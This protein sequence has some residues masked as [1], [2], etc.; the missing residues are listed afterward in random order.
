MHRIHPRA[1]HT[2]PQPP[3][4]TTLH[5]CTLLTACVRVCVV[6]VGTRLGFYFE[7]LATLVMPIFVVVSA[8]TMVI[9]MRWSAGYLRLGLPE[10]VR[11]SVHFLRWAAARLWQ[12]MQTR[13]HVTHP[14]GTVSGGSGVSP[15]SVPQ[16]PAEEEAEAVEYND[17]FD[18]DEE[19][20]MYIPVKRDADGN[21]ILPGGD[22]G[23]AHGDSGASSTEALSSPS[24]P[25]SP[26]PLSSAPPVSAASREPSRPLQPSASMVGTWKE[27]RRLWD[28]REIQRKGA[29]RA[30]GLVWIRVGDESSLPPECTEA[31]S[32]PKLE[33]SL[34]GR[35]QV[36]FTA[37]QWASFAVGASLRMRHYVAV[38]GECFRPAGVA[39]RFRWMRQSDE[40][41][42][43]LGVGKACNEPAM[44]KLLIWSALILCAARAR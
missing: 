41:A 8:F 16:D 39:P 44:Y 36:E 9:V 21:K 33:A 17:E 20:D 10:R 43:W 22:G 28:E 4:L 27:T 13:K 25:P 31:L 23:G 14:R 11:R 37:E 26:P 15:P 32:N 18:Y 35:A 42:D 29:R 1:P 3:L 12:C 6:Q 2:G 30:S 5:A 24:P 7:L 40:T 34:K 19:H 38:R